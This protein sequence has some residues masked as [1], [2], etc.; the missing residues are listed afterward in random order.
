MLVH[1]KKVEFKKERLSLSRL[2]LPMFCENKEGTER[3]RG[4]EKID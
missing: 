4:R 3:E 2:N 1:I